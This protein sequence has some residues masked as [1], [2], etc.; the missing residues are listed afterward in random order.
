MTMRDFPTKLGDAYLSF[1]GRVMRE[2]EESLT[3]YVDSSDE[4]K[5]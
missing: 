1:L 2:I 4:I 3:R 5:P